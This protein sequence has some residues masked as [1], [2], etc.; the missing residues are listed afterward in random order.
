MHLSSELSEVMTE[1]IGVDNF[2]KTRPI[3]TSVFSAVCEEMG[4][5]HHAVLFHSEARR[6]SPGKVLSRLFEL[7]EQIRMFLEQEHKCK[8][9][10][11]FSDETF[12]AK[13]AGLSGKLN[14]L[15]LQLQGKDENLQ[16]TRSTLSLE[17]LQR[18]A[19]ELMKETQIH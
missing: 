14:E 5:E 18:E 13:L 15:N 19:G 12:L 2:I 6:L 11:K 1:I 9:A 4:A 7:R 8:V 17:S 10:E 16:G 3:K